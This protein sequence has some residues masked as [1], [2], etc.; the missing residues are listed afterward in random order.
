MKIKLLTGMAGSNYS[1][2]PGEEVDMDEATA[3]RLIAKD[4]AVEVKAKAP[5]RATRVVKPPEER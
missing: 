2:S 3:K 5:R 4:M 1:Y